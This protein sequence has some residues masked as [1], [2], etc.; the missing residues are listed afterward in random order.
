MSINFTAEEWA[1]LSPANKTSALLAAKAD[2]NVVLTTNSSTTP[3]FLKRNLK[4]GDLT[5]FLIS[6]TSKVSSAT[7]PSRANF[8]P[9]WVPE[10]T[11]IRRFFVSVTG[12]GV[13]ALG[14][15][16]LYS[17]S[18]ATRGGGSLIY[19][20]NEIDWSAVGDIPTE[21]LS[22]P[23]VLTPDVYY[24]GTFNNAVTPTVMQVSSGLGLDL[25]GYSSSWLQNTVKPI[26]LAPAVTY[27]NPIS[28]L[29][30]AGESNVRPVLVTCEVF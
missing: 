13:G 23:L 20:S 21:S 22:S 12:I 8:Y 29:E 7:G 28:S 15:V 19:S 16:A 18:L 10:T 5:D 4:S 9:I 27:P 3:N 26:C 14:K 2:L 25:G 1:A 17:R 24:I 30:G 11:R 6:S